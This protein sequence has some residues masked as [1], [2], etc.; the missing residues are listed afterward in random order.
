MNVRNDNNK[1]ANMAGYSFPITRVVLLLGSWD[2]II[3]IIIII[4]IM[5]V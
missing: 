5:A 1:K 3:I 4:I 2:I